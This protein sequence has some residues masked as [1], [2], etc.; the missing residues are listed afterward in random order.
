[1][2]VTQSV[3]QIAHPTKVDTL[4]AEVHRLHSTIDSLHR[5][6]HDLGIASTYYHD[7]INMNVA[8]FIGIIT[9]IG[10]I[11]GFFSWRIVKQTALNVREELSEQLKLQEKKL[12][13][14]NEAFD[15]K[16]KAI[17]KKNLYHSFNTSRLMYV[18]AL[19]ISSFPVA[20]QWALNTLIYSFKLKDRKHTDIWLANVKKLLSKELKKE[21]LIDTKDR[22]D[23]HL[24]KLKILK[25][26]DIDKIIKDVEDKVYKVIYSS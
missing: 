10:G 9:L 15:G 12:A 11:I 6:V 3:A 23:R 4:Q 1:M 24:S 19:N 13:G 5:E 2:N 8:T 7:I 21:E 26:D 20:L 16:M 14:F 22:I 25:K 18:A 17:D